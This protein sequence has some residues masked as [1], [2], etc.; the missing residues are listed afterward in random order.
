MT[1]KS[2]MTYMCLFNDAQLGSELVLEFKGEIRT[3]I[4]LI[5]CGCQICRKQ[6]LFAYLFFVC[7][8][9]FNLF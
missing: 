1:Y 5:R 9:N 7:G 8:P 6:T 3:I 2:T 4:I